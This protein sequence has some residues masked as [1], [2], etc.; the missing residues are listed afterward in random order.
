MEKLSIE[1]SNGAIGF[2]LPK[3]DVPE[4][5]IEEKIPSHLLR[6]SPLNLPQISENE[7]FRHFLRLSQLNYNIDKGIYPLGSCTMKYNPKINEELARNSKFINIHPHTLD[8]FSQ[9]CLAII[10]ELCE[11]LKEISG[12][13]D[14]SLQPSAGAQ[15]EL[16]GVLIISKYHKSKGEKREIILVPDSAHGTNPATAT[17]AGLNT[18]EIKTIETNG[19]LRA[20]LIKNEIE[21]YGEKI[22]GLMITNPNTLGIFEEEILEISE[23]LHKIDAQVYMDG[24][25]MNALVGNVKP[26]NFGVDVMHF[27]LHKTFSTP[28]GGGGPGS[29]AVAVKNHLK[30]FLPNP[31]IRKVNNKYQLVYEDE[32]FSIGRLHS[33]YGNFGMFIRALSYIRMLSSEGLKYVSYL[34]TLNANYLRK[35]LEEIGYKIS[36]NMPTMHEF[37]LT[38]KEIKDKYNVKALDVAKKL[39]D[40]GFHPPTIYFPLIVEEAFMIEPTESESKISLDS[41]I[42][43][44]EKILNEIKQNPELLLNAPINTPVS[45]LD[46][47]KAAKELKVKWQDIN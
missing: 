20:K 42:E 32:E 21:K 46:E 4:F 18:I 14:V 44:Y 39:L 28:H 41:Y 29:G 37:V 13:D 26:G 12:M 15:G 24:A 35:R 2:S 43:A 36:F 17:L 45:R 1:L 31:R 30:K 22:A 3:L 16:A 7:T 40:Y 33:F 10:Y 38:L 47:V 11:L 19:V 6:K 27:N 34:S 23:L 8:E 5:E 25:N 9:G